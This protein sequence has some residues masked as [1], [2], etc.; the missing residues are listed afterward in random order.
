MTVTEA[1]ERLDH[2]LQ[3]APTRLAG[4]SELDASAKVG[5]DRWAPKEILGHLIDSASNNH[6]RFVRGQLLPKLD[7]PSYEQERWVATQAYLTEP[8]VDLVALWL[9]YNRHLLHI[10]RNV[11][12]DALGTPILIRG[13]AP[14][15]L[16]TVIADYVT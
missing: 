12:E 1:A 8:W 15:Q 11:R 4:I 2:I 6:Q 10:V 9:L 7:D 5:P 14:V 13:G 16:S 3:T